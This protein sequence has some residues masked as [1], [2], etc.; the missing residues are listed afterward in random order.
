MTTYTDFVGV[1]NMGKKHLTW[2]EE[3]Y[4]II[5][6]LVGSNGWGS[7]SQLSFLLLMTGWC[8]CEIIVL[9]N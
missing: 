2:C 6:V 1:R 4:S 7:L 8:L 3:L 5:S 9:I